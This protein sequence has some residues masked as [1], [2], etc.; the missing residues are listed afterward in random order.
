MYWAVDIHFGYAALIGVST[1]ASVCWHVAHEPRHHI[2]FYIDYGLAGLWT[3]TD[4][5]FAKNANILGAIIALNSIALITNHIHIPNIPYE[6]T[7]SLWHG[8]SCAKA[9]LVAYILNKN[10]NDYRAS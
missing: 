9:C 7:H 10:P 3:I 4:L 1:G 8:L 6:I 5:Y 2:L